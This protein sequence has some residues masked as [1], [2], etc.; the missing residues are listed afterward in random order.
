MTSRKREAGFGGRVGASDSVSARTRLPGWTIAGLLTGDANELP[1][2]GG[3][4]VRRGFTSAGMSPGGYRAHTSRLS[5]N[6]EPG[7]NRVQAPNLCHFRNTRTRFLMTRETGCHDTER[8]KRA[9]ESRAADSCAP[10]PAPLPTA[11]H[12]TAAGGGARAQ[13]RLPTLRGCGLYL[14][15]PLPQ[16]PP[17]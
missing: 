8:E 1:A 15:P 16:A 7:L 3:G 10:P 6:E 5:W 14:L 13:R 17:V 2:V 12:V 9:V 4:A 11:L